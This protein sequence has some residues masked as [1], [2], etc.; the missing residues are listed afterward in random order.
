M[1]FVFMADIH[2]SGYG[3]DK[4]DSKSNLP[5]RLSFIKNTLYNISDYC[6]KNNI[7]NIKI[8]GDILHNK[9]LIYTIAQNVILEFIRD[10]KNITFDILSGNH[11][12]SGRGSSAVSALKALDN[13]PNV[14]GIHSVYKD[15]LNDILYVPYMKGMVDIIKNSKSKYLIS[16]FGLSEGIL[17]SGIS[18]ISELKLSDLIGKY[19]IVLLGHYHLPQEIIRDNIKVYYSGSIIQLD[20]GERNEEKRFLVV[21]TDNDNIESIPTEGYKKHFR[22]SITKENEEEII[23]KANELRNIGHYVEFEKKDKFDTSILE[24]EFRI[25]DKTDIDIT[26]RGINSSMSISEKINRYLE[27]K[28]IPENQ[29]E[30]YKEIANEC[31]EGSI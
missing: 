1:K 2:A 25:I 12:L 18:V 14:N 8:G 16:H 23:Q 9:S 4:I 11:D 30:F 27:I 7:G 24:K 6:N 17:N 20:L 22:F 26:N 19:E 15:S 5:E 28:E 31:I 29:I 13:E 10:N 21:D 3:N